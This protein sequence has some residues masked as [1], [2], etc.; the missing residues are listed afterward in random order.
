MWCKK[1]IRFGVMLMVVM[2]VLAVAVGSAMA[3]K[4]NKDGKILKKVSVEGRLAL[5]DMRMARVA[6]FDGMPEQSG[7][8]LEQAK[9]NLTAAKKQASE[10]KVTTKGAKVT[11]LVPIDVAVALSED[12]VATP[13]KKEKIKEA[14]EHLRKGESAKAVEIL[15][16]ADISVAISS[17]LMPLKATIKHVDQAIALIKDHKYY[18]ANLTLKGAED[19]VIVVTDMLSEP[20][21]PAKKK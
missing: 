7:K 19:G 3:T 12:F 8:L 9:K 15:R 17:V 20:I 14:N 21:T 16:Q 6:I 11:D 10:M 4:E 2:L 5:L 13:E 1:Q 18:E